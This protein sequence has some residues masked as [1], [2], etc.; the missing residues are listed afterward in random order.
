[1]DKPKSGTK[2]KISKKR[3]EQ[4][5]KYI[6]EIDNNTKQIALVLKELPTTSEDNQD[7]IM[8]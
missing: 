4:I 2:G 3:I 5:E 8:P 6:E 7:N 1:M